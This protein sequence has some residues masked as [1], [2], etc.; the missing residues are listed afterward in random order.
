MRPRDRIKPWF[1]PGI[2]GIPVPAVR[3]ALINPP[4]PSSSDNSRL[5]APLGLGYLAAFAEKAGFH[6]DVF[7]LALDLAPDVDFLKLIGV[8]DDYQVY[9]ITTYTES[10]QSAVQLAKLIRKE[11]PRSLVVFGGYHVSILDVETLRDFSEIDVV[12]RG[13][14]EVRFSRLLQTFGLGQR[15]FPDIPSI[16]W[17]SPLGEIIRNEDDQFLLDQDSLP[18]PRTYARYGPPTYLN[19]FDWKNGLEKTSISMVSS[20]GCPKRCTFCSIAILNPLWRARSVASMMDEITARYSA[21]PFSHIFFQDA[22]FFVRPSRSLDFSRALYAFNPNITW[23]GTATPDH[24]V[25][26]EAVIAEIGGL[27][28]SF[29]GVGIESGNEGSLARYGKGNDLA[30]NREAIRILDEA[31]IS[32]ALDFIMFEPEM[33]LGDVLS[34]LD[35]LAEFELDAEWPTN[36]FQ[37]L[38]FYPGTVART[39]FLSRCGGLVSDHEIP[40]TLFF[41]P[42]VQAVFDFATYFRLRLQPSINDT[43]RKIYERVYPAIRLGP[44][45]PQEMIIYSQRCFEAAI[46][47]RHLPFAMLRDYS[48]SI[49][50]VG[51]CPDSIAHIAGVEQRVSSLLRKAR[52]QYERLEVC[53]RRAG[54]AAR[55]SHQPSRIAHRV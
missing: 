34:N 45:A 8:F 7:D 42:E 36:L 1:W 31:G 11:R 16:T 4:D 35:F 2:A 3:A 5:V 30:T 24:I 17:R 43:I 44:D 52:E 20:R 53:N 12:V 29:V 51:N 37:E 28:C 14:G 21:S 22:N 55:Q 46:R 26:H 15:Q 19:F 47:L 23:S 13:E 6:V 10:F 32:L 38:Q 18:Y 40:T 48:A 50:D 54:L 25:K 27:N 39:Q 9:G 33:S 49:Y 41:D